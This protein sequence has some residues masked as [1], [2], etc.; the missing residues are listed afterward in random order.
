VSGR[1]GVVVIAGGVRFWSLAEGGSGVPARPASCP[2]LSAGVAARA[3]SE[4]HVEASYAGLAG[5]AGRMP[6]AWREN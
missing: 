1:T 4:G 6:R 2:A 5:E 3:A